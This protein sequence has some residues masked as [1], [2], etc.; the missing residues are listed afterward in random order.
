MG[1]EQPVDALE[2]GATLLLREDHAFA[3]GA[4]QLLEVGPVQ[5]LRVR[6]LDVLDRPVEPGLVDAPGGRG[7]TSLAKDAPPDDRV[8]E[9]RDPCLTVVAGVPDERDPA[10]RTQHPRDLEE[11]DRMVEP[12]ERLGDGHDV[13]GLVVE[14]DRLGGARQRDRTGNGRPQLRQHLRDR[15]DRRHAMSERDERAGQ[16]PRPC[17]EVDDVAGL[18]A[19]EPSDGLLGIAGA[20]PLVHVRDRSEGQP[21]SAAIGVGRHGASVRRGPRYP[22]RM[23]RAAL[24][25][26]LVALLAAG[27]GGTTADD[28][29][30][31]YDAEAPLALETGAQLADGRPLDVREISFASGGER[32]DGVLVAPPGR[33]RRVPAVVYLHGS[34]GDRTQLLPLASSLAARGAVALTLTLPSGDATPPTGLS[35]EETLRWQRDT[36]VEDVVAV[37]RA[38]D[39]LAADERVDPERL[40]L[41]GWSFGGRLGALVAGIDDRVRA[42]AL[43]SAGAAPVAEYAAAAPAD[44]R[45]DVEEVLTPIDPLARIGEAQGAVFLQAG[46][47]DSVVPAS[48]LQALAD[49]APDDS[50]ITWYD[51][52]HQLDD[53]ANRDQLDWLAERLEVRPG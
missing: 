7:D 43:M 19:G 17:P 25:G 46:R 37:R 50:R 2:H 38:L 21:P 47:S 35:P 22:R 5:R 49:A 24:L 14:G 36:I 6:E 39:V 45:D 34:G 9:L 11:R 28:D 26:L 23:L 29:T 18:A 15:L 48:A 4:D 16:L 42:T 10:A 40:G 20:R 3:P 8:A 51:A 41:V 33:E 12:V 27:C 32:V 1:V 53:R 31:A 30:F 44:L 52:E 13:R